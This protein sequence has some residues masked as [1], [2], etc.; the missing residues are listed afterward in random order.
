MLQSGIRPDSQ[1]YNLL[2]RTARDCGIG[3]LALA[4][5]V[6]LKTDCEHQKKSR[7]ASES[8]SPGVIDIDVLERQLFLQPD[9]HVDH[10]QEGRRSEEESNSR[11]QP[12]TQLIPVTQNRDLPQPVDVGAGST[13]PNLLDIFE[14]KRGAVISLCAVDGP[15]D[16]LALI[17][18]A[19]GVLEKM[20][21]SGLSPDLRTLT[22]LADTMEP[23]YESLQL[24]LRVAKQHRVKVDVAFFNSVIRRTARAS[25]LEAAKVLT[26]T[27]SLFF[28]SLCR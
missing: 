23:G 17:G 26:R 7:D 24:L 16:R 8:R 25:D 4:A 15:S 14:G 22:L 18:G 11:E 20:A 27:L 6:L 9:P 5:G 12:S 13:P 2:L 1:N 28:Q 3:D 21:A 10:E 19:Q